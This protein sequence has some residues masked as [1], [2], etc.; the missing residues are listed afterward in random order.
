MTAAQFRRKA[1]ALF[2]KGNP[3]AVDATITW[4]F[5][6][7]P[8]VGKGDGRPGHRTGTFVAAASGYRQ[9]RVMVDYSPGSGWSVR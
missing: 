6:S 3:D 1:E 7:R 8:F 5:T 4:T 9:R 2:H